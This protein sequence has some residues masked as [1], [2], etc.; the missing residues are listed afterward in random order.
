MSRIDDC[1]KEYKNWCAK[2]G[3]VKVSD[4]NKIIDAGGTNW[5]VNISEAW[6]EQKISEIA[7]NIKNNIEHKKI[8]LISGP[9]SSGKTTFANRLQLHLKVL[10]VN[11]VSISLDNYYKKFS[12][13]PL[14]DEG[15][16]DFEALESIDYQQ[17]NENVKD[18]I[19]G[20]E[21]FLPVYDFESRVRIPN[22]IKLQLASDEV[23]IVE[24]IHG[25]NPKLTDNI[26]NENKYRIYCSALSALVMDNDVRIK[27]RSNRLVRRLI[28]DYYFRKSDYDLTMELWPN[29]ERGAEKNIFPYTDSADVIFNSSLLYESCIYKKYLLDIIKNMPDDDV[30]K[31]QIDEL[32]EI[33]SSF[34]D[35]SVDEVPKISLIR[36]FVG[37]NTLYN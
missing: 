9:S 5:L 20:K 8:I 14:T 19:E 21:T 12:E 37:G 31:P 24:G 29:V 36:E 13:M 1:V 25:L 26:S 18:L 6:H 34:G 22:A 32:V 33:V 17:F 4:V 30:Y 7:K 10:G 23:I 28:R 3:I 2:L 16:P 35:I 27:S 15:K 11:A